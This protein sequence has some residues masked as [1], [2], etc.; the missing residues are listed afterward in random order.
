MKF[1][2]YCQID[3]KLIP[4]HRRLRGSRTCSND[5]QKQYIKQKKMERDERICQQCG[6]PWDR[7][8]VQRFRKWLDREGVQ[9][10]N[11]LNPQKS[12]LDPLKAIKKHAFVVAEP[13]KGRKRHFTPPRRKKAA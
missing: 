4:D 13:P 2:T 3:R 1:R 5:C 6:R 12:L 7:E 9:L 8:I 10:K 11:C